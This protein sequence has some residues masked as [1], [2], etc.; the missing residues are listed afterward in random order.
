MTGGAEILSYNLQIDISGGG[1]GPW[2]DAKDY[3]ELSAELSPLT[4]G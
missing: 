2:L 1:S 3:L 4:E